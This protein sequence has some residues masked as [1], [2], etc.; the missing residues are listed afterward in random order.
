MRANKMNLRVQILGDNKQYF[1]VVEQKEIDEFVNEMVVYRYVCGVRLKACWQRF[2]K[3]FQWQG[4][5]NMRFLHCVH[6][7]R[8]S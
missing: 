4:V 7:L 8:T 2:C 6:G 1:S 5:E 3:S